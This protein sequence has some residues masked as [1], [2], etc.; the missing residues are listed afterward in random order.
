MIPDTRI[1]GSRARPERP[2]LRLVDANLPLRTQL[3]N[4][5]NEYDN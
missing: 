1:I 5:K 4:K 2:G 3:T